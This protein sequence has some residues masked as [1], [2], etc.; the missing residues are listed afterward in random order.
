MIADLEQTVMQSTS[1]VVHLS[2]CDDATP[3]K[4]FRARAD[5]VEYGRSRVQSGSAEL[6]NIYE[7]AGADGVAAIALW[8][9]GDATHIQTCSRQ[10]SDSEIETANQQASDTAR[11]AGSRAELK[12][13]GLIRRDA[14]DPPKLP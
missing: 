2:G 3:F 9:A 4:H 5:A 12:Y 6:A 13:L 1:Y 11:K 14:P 10:A 8:Q 7:V